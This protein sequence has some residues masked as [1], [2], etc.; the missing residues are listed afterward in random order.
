VALVE[1]LVADTPFSCLRRDRNRFLFSR[2]TGPKI[3]AL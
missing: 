1:D 3:A 2:A